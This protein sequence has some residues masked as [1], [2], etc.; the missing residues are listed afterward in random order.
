MTLTSIKNAAKSAI[1]L[2]TDPKT[3]TEECSIDIEE[4]RMQHCVK[5]ELFDKGW[6]SSKREVDGIKG[7]G[8]FLP[9]K[10]SLLNQKCPRELW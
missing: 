10:I 7:C 9:I 6:C 5:C 4:E 2:I 3:F 8:C 1:E